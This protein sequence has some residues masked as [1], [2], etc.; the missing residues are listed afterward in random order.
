[1]KYIVIT[2]KHHDGFAL[3]DSEVSEFDVMATPFERDIMAELAEACR[4]H[5]LKMCWYH[6]IMDWHHPDY[7]PRRG[8]EVADRPA[9]GADFDRFAAY[10]H[11]QVTELL[12]N[13]GPIGIMWFDG[14]WESTWNHSYGQPLYDLCL[15]LQP[16]V[17]VNNRVDKGR[18]GMAGLTEDAMYAGDYGTPEQEIP[19]TGLPGVDWETCMTMNN[20]WG[21]NAA[22]KN[23]KSVETLI[24]MLI[25]IAS[26]GGNYLLNV[27]PT[28]EGLFPPESVER[29]AA[30]GD[31]MEVNGEAIY[32]TSA[33]P[34]ADLPWGRC[35]VKRKGRRSILYLHVFERPADGRLVVPGI[36]NDAIQ[37][38][39]LASGDRLAVQRRDTDLEIW[40]PAR[41]SDPVATVVTLELHGAPVVYETP[42]IEAD[43]Q[44]LVN[45]LAVEMRTRSP[46]IVIRYTLDGSE[47]DAGAPVYD[48]PV[49]IDRTTTV[50]ARSF[51]QGDPVSAVAEARFEKAAPLAALQVSGTVPG[52]VRETYHGN[53]D[54]LPDF[55]ALPVAARA[56]VADLELPR[57]GRVEYVGHRFSGFIEV[58]ADEVYRFL[59][60]SDDGS[61][62]SIDGR[63]VIDN[64]GLHGSQTGSGE[65]ALAAGRHE[66]T[67]EWFNKTGGADL[68]LRYQRVG[69]ESEPVPAAA[70]SHR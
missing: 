10:L 41:L 46:D 68:G 35:T 13:Y 58:P 42:V 2:S 63:L 1:M 29:L 14:E 50:R 24:R 61:R 30:I 38:R 55:D 18:G 26:K 11:A 62:L 44:I 37:A 57:S 19:A 69:R 3:F 21:W 51:H 47:P 8:W 27:G 25:D 49:T 43:S 15:E 34:F 6:S 5:G 23:F 7:L 48:G 28:A 40:L 67:V 20:H 56:T 70:F 36:G 66:L 39:L 52:L 45:T 33:S 32:G 17:I 53:W 22:D 54:V 64:D 60:T 9:E 16:D 12:T 31:W 65:I 4:R 59:L